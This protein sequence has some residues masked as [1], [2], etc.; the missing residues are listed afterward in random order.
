MCTI[1]VPFEGS[2]LAGV[3]STSLSGGRAQVVASP[4]D[5]TSLI[6]VVRANYRVHP[7]YIPDFTPDMFGRFG[8]EKGL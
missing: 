3:H 5:S 1:T 4:R 6:E 8:E 7:P 2:D